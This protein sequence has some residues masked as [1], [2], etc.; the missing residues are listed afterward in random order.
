RKGRRLRNHACA[1]QD[2]A[3]K[4]GIQVNRS[5]GGSPGTT[6]CGGELTGNA[7]ERSAHRSVK[8]GSS[9]CPAEHRIISIR[10]GS[11]TSERDGAAVEL[12][13]CRRSE[14]SVTRVQ[15]PTWVGSQPLRRSLACDVSGESCASWS[16]G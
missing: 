3:T 6:S 4:A 5:G 16:V 7:R 11:H 15:C 2:H 1:T 14:P 9:T 10:A 12:T 8:A 13:C